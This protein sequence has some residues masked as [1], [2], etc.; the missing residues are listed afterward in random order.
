[1]DTPTHALMIFVDGLGL[2]P[3]GPKNP[4]TRPET[5]VLFRWLNE[6]AVPVDAALGVP[7][8][9]QSATGQT[10]LLTGVNAARLLGR[11]AEGFPGPTLRASIRERN[12]FRLLTERGLRC[13]FA[14]AYYVTDQQDLRLH[15]LQSVTTVMTLSALGEVRDARALEEDR[16]VYHDLTREALR[17]RGY[18]G[19]PIAPEEAADHLM[20]MAEENAFTLFEFFQSDQ[21]G[22]GGEAD[23]IRRVLN[24]L[25][26][27][28]GRLERFVARPGRLLIL[29]SDHGNIEDSTVRTH[30]LNP[31]PLVA[32][33][34]GSE[35]L[36]TRVR[37]LTDFT[38]AV[39]DQLKS[40]D[41]L[42]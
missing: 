11:H 20:R 4:I 38:P 39:L 31:V 16:A 22:H 7:G 36:K 27:F 17:T 34:A 8:L 12:L 15:R 10:A 32:L 13:A 14:N 9:P 37:A 28:L 42:P 33:G 3:P 1:M 29:T 40:L 25:D 6:A 41:A 2:A 30:T 26:R 35:T 19:P 23:R 24:R 5:P 18:A 21:A